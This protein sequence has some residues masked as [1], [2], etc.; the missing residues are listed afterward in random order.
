MPATATIGGVTL[1]FWAMNAAGTWSTTADEL[2]A[3]ARS[4]SGAV[5][6]RSTTVHPFLHPEFRSLHNP[7][8]DR[9]VP[10]IAELKP[11]GKPLVASIAGASVD[12]YVTLARAFAEAGADLIEVNLA[13]PYV[14]ATLDP[15][16]S[17]ASLLGI[18]DDVRAAGRPLL[19][20]CPERIPLALGELR[21]VLIDA[22]VAA[23][24]LANT[25][26]SMERFF[27]ERTEPTP[28][29]IAF[30]GVKSGYDLA[31]ALRK[32]AAAVQVTSALTLEGP[33]VF[34]RIAREYT[35]LAGAGAGA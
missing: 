11:F 10:L 8:Y 21:S 25:F 15:W 6:F 5:V 3:L 17:R 2:A 27:L 13:D 16:A 22:Q 20:R 35:Q 34:A 31:T 30:G 33:R 24:V 19:V 4:N 12:E 23:V 7:G 29:V 9:Y 1:P 14:T 18:L 28:A 26:D 32:G